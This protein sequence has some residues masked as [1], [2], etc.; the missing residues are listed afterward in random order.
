MTGR[1]GDGSLGVGDAVK[2]KTGT[3]GVGVFAR[4]WEEAKKLGILPLPLDAGADVGRISGAGLV[5]DSD[6]DTDGSFP[7]ARVGGFGVPSVFAAPKD[8]R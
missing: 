8:E 1:V 6:I 5:L 2:F 4:N 7:D 3:G